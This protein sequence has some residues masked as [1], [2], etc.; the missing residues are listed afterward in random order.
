[1]PAAIPDK[2]CPPHTI[3]EEKQP[4]RPPLTLA[5]PCL[6]GMNAL[7][8]PCY[9]PE[10]GPSCL[11]LATWGK[12]SS[13]FGG[14]DLLFFRARDP[15]FLIW[16]PQLMVRGQPIATPQSA[17]MVRLFLECSVKHH[18]HKT[19]CPANYT[20]PFLDMASFLLCFS[21]QEFL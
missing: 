16:S 2:L 19:S 21:S 12:I 8:E 13:S 18:A 5:A 9:S 7:E 14:Q 17:I 4:P 6:R 3:T 1:M 11:P 10:P 20:Q 15:V